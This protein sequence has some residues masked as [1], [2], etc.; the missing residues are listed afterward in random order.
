MSEIKLKRFW[1][2]L[3]G[4]F[5]TLSGAAASAACVVDNDDRI[6]L[7]VSPETKSWGDYNGNKLI[8]A[9]KVYKCEQDAGRYLM[10][11][12]G[13]T[14]WSASTDVKDTYLFDTYEPETC[15]LKNSKA[16]ASYTPER[17]KANFSRQYKFIRSCF[18]LRV[19]DMGGAQIIAKENQQYCKV[20]RTSDGAVILRGDMCFLKI[21][22]QSNFAVQ[23]IFNNKCADPDY[24][25]S[26]GVQAQDI[27]ANLNILTTG[28]DS[29]YSED[30]DNIGSRALHINITPNSKVLNLS[31]DFGASVPRFPTSYNINADWGDL[32]IHTDFENKTEIDLSF[33]V[34][35]MAS[36]KCVAGE[37]SSSSNFTQPFVGQVELFKLSSG[38]PPKLVEEW[39]DGGLVPPNWQGFVKGIQYRVPDT[40]VDAGGRY[41]MVATFQD[42]TDD[43]AIYLNGLRQMLLRMYDV[44][45][46]TVGVDTLPALATL[47]T[48]G[49]IPGFNGTRVLNQNNQSVDLSQTLKGLEEIISS[50]VW[51]PYYSAICDHDKCTKIKNRKFHQRLVL[52]FVVGRPEVGEDEVKIQDI[53]MQ[54]ISPIF[55]N[56]PM[57][58]ADFVSLQCGG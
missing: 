53:H 28:D 4:L 11:S 55:D 6:Q 17:T 49:V 26:I 40:V 14:Q 38:R 12:M 37:C 51:P 24:L 33:F 42:P 58:K 5:F 32:K 34:S 20:E 39:W 43:Y 30:V 29:G 9:S 48:L 56:Y 10:L 22:A 45:G 21:R 19:V 23:P 15:S 41:R 35:N 13:A 27:Y 36:E 46:A 3:L 16:F 18:D 7:N 50:T 8:T 57:Q 1:S 54:K 25:R 44:E 31:E 47:N 52:E 2:L